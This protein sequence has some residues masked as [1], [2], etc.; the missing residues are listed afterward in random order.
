MPH[1]LPDPAPHQPPTRKP[2]HSSPPHLCMA[3]EGLLVQ[4]VCCAHNVSGALSCTYV[5]WCST[6]CMSSSKASCLR[7]QAK[8]T[9]ACPVWGNALARTQDKTSF[10]ANHHSSW[11][12]CTGSASVHVDHVRWGDMQRMRLAPAPAPA[13]LASHHSNTS[14]KLCHMPWGGAAGP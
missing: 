12:S 1:C 9:C 11:S 3:M 2:P 10:R 4:P 14:T 13:C 6:T 7:R 8:C 5:Q